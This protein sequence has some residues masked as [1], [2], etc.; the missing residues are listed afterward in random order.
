MGAIFLAGHIFPTGGKS[1]ASPQL[2]P[3]QTGG[4]EV[5]RGVGGSPGASGSWLWA[6]MDPDW[7]G[8][9]VWPSCPHC[10][11]HPTVKH[12][13]LHGAGAA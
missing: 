7:R 8:T 11:L 1:C 12:L 5:H 6:G 9:S 4:P 2:N 10:P 13:C 3:F